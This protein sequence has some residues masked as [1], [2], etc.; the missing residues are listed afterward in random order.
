MDFENVDSFYDD[1]CEP[2]DPPSGHTLCEQ[3]HCTAPYADQ[4]CLEALKDHVGG[5]SVDLTF[6]LVD[7]DEAIASQYRIPAEPIQDPQTGE[8]A[9]VVLRPEQ[10]SLEHPRVTYKYF[11]SMDCELGEGCIGG[12]GWRR[13]LRFNAD[14]SNVGVEDMIVGSTPNIDISM[15]QYNIYEFSNCHKH[16]HFSH[17]GNFWFGQVQESTT[18]RGFCLESDHR[19]HNTE[20]SP[21]HNDFWSCTYQGLAAGWLDSYDDGLPCQ[22]VDIT[23]LDTSTAPHTDTLYFQLNPDGFMCEVKKLH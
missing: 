11:T 8:A 6:T 3:C 5:I 16:F 10:G 19:I 14:A 9:P 13:L 18:K 17:Y 4:T 15:K 2:E 22:W 23:S 12:L 7:F 21:L 1:T 20:S